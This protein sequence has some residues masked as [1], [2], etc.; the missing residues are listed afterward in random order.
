MFKSTF[1]VQISQSTE[2][3]NTQKTKSSSTFSISKVSSA[4]RESK[5]F[6]IPNLKNKC[7]PALRSVT[8]IQLPTALSGASNIKEKESAPPA[9]P[10]PPAPQ[11][12]KEVKANKSQ[13][14]NKAEQSNR[15]QL[16]EE[17]RAG[18]KLKPTVPQ[19]ENKKASP[20]TELM[21]EIRSKAK[22]FSDNRR[23]S[24]DGSDIPPPP[25]LPKATTAKQPGEG[26]D[27]L[28]AEISSFSQTLLKKTGRL[29]KAVSTTTKHAE[30]SQVDIFSDSLM[31][32]AQKV[33][34]DS[35]LKIS[36]NISQYLT[37][38][39]QVDW[40]KVMKSELKGLTSTSALEQALTDKPQYLQVMWTEISKYPDVY[41]QA[42]VVSDE[43]PKHKS[44]RDIVEVA[45]TRL[46]GSPHRIFR[47]DSKLGQVELKSAQSIL[48]SMAQKASQ[49]LPNEDKLKLLGNGYKDALFK[50]FCELPCMEGF[51]QQN[52]KVAVQKL[53]S[54]FCSSIESTE[55][56]QQN[57]CTFMHQHLANGF[58]S[59][60]FSGLEARL[61]E[62]E[63]ALAAK[64]S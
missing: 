28:L 32:S 9:P 47:S 26:R 14:Q 41:K 59:F 23:P 21:K 22:E 55:S 34:P 42:D 5:L 40:Q 6:G 44:G 31:Q 54:A 25:P 11:L 30:P 63:A 20:E 17:I 50:A 15:S 43:S 56:A 4:I 18:V 38:A 27:Q 1:K 36:E 46:S 3:P 12:E 35:L 24:N 29:E 49:S 58:Q 57:I 48:E 13:I 37:A 16:M 8:K 53:K 45:M 19:A 7:E 61:K 39:M 10:A 51:E 2:Q 64:L 60:T 52:G 62:L 33:A